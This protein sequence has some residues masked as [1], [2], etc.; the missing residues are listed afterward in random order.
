MTA[1]AE[2]P[3]WPVVP[4]CHGWLA[5]DRRG[6]WRLRGEP[7]RHPGLIGFIN[8]NYRADEAG[9]WVVRNGPQKVYVTLAYT[10]WVVRL[11]ADEAPVLHSGEPAGTVDAVHLDD[12]GSVLLATSSGIAL[13]DDRDLAAFLAA[14]HVEGG[15][16]VDD[17]TLCGLMDGKGRAWWKG[18]PITAISARDVPCTYG[19]EPAP[20]P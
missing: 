1:S 2:L 16:P 13:L 19:F 20:A 7:V 17:E 3:G 14:C 8:A 4:D 6:V 10:P 11:G 15:A 18:V 5:L 12:E 9:R